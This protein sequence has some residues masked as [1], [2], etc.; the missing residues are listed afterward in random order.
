M[1]H[2]MGAGGGA[3]KRKFASGFQ[4]WLKSGKNK[5]VIYMGGGLAGFFFCMQPNSKFISICQ[6][7][8][9]AF[10]PFQII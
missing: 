1:K 3:F 10:A 8:K 4:F 6:F 7:K 9:Y 2:D 5:K